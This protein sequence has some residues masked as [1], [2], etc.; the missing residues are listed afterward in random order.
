MT[1]PPPRPRGPR[2]PG[3]GGT[4]TRQGHEAG[5]VLVDDAHAHAAS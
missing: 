3:P 2:A 5:G 1:P 4:D